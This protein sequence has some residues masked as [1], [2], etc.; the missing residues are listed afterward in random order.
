MDLRYEGV[1]PPDGGGI[2][3]KSLLLPSE[4]LSTPLK[5]GSHFNTK[6]MCYLWVPNLTNNTSV[7]VALQKR[8]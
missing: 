8:C 4:V 7:S 1:Y 3:T 2:T 5:M 6:I